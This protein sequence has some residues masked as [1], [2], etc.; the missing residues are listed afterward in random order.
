VV[1]NGHWPTSQPTYTV[2]HGKRFEIVQILHRSG[3][4][5]FGWAEIAAWRGAMRLPET[6]SCGWASRVERWRGGLGAAY[7]L[8]ALSFAGASITVPCSVSTSRSSNRTCGFPASGFRTRTH[9]FRP[10]NVAVAQSQLDK[11]QFF[12]QVFVGK[13]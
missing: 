1:A 2:G 4:L 9:A 13:A 12:M 5:G 3:L 7:L 6:T 11:P 10:R 8:P